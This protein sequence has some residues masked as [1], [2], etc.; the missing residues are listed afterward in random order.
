MAPRQKTIVAVDD[1]TVFLMY[2][3]ILLKRMGFEVVP[4]ESGAEALRVVRLVEPDLVML[5]VVMPGMDGSAGAWVLPA[6]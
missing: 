2:V 5:D 1:S 4:V 6:T 3:S